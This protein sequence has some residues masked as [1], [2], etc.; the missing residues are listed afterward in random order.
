M[1]IV[2]IG[3]RG[4]G[5]STVGRLVAA[6]LAMQFVDADEELERRAGRSIREIFASGGESEFRDLESNVV[7]QLLQRDRLVAALG[8]GAVLRNENRQQI[9]R[10]NN[11]VFWLQAE[12]TT[13]HQRISSDLGTSQRRPDLTS[14]GGLDEVV[15]LLAVREPLYR[16]CA[17]FT[18]DTEAK[19]PET[20]AAEIVSL[21]AG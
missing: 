20:V 5:K 21:V 16:E 15:R 4:T 3:Y 18:V 19:S 2:L 14:A 12:A 10:Q 17:E 6:Q 8:G 9:R 13:L 7:A 11:R 1:N